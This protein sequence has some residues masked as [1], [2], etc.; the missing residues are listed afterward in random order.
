MPCSRLENS[1]IVVS[2]TLPYKG[3]CQQICGLCFILQG[4]FFCVAGGL[5]EKGDGGGGEEKGWGRGEEK[6]W[7]EGGG[8]RV[9][10]LSTYS[11]VY[12]AYIVE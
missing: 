5:E 1:F 8:L 10:P 12:G 2:K 11:T 3:S 6:G 9:P 4:R 7:G